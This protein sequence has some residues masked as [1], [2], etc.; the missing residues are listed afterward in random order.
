V[1]YSFV[2]GRDHV[3]GLRQSDQRAVARGDGD[4]RLVAMFLHGQDHLGFK[5][6]A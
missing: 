1:I 6:I 4:F 3:G 5:F 2:D